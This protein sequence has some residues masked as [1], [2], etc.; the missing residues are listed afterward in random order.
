MNNLTNAFGSLYLEILLNVT[1]P[2]RR[3]LT[4]YSG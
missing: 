2:I 1:T 4:T 3:K